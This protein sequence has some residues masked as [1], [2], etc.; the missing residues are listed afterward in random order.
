MTTKPPRWLVRNVQ[1]IAGPPVDVDGALAAAHD[2]DTEREGFIPARLSG[3]QV[4]STVTGALAAAHD[5]DTEREGFIPARLSDTALRAAFVSGDAVRRNLRGTGP[6]LTKYASNPIFSVGQ[7]SSPVGVSGGAIQ[8][9]WIVN[10]VAETGAVGPYG[11]TYRIYFSSD[12]EG[13]TASVGLLTAAS[14]TGPWTSRGAIYAD[15]VTDNQTETASVVWNPV[16][17]LWFMYYHQVS[18][19]GAGAAECTILATSADGV[20]NWT[21]VGI[22]MDYPTNGVAYLPANGGIGYA[23]P[24]RF[25][26]RWY[27]HSLLAGGNYGTCALWSSDDGRV[28]TMDVRPLGFG[29]DLVAAGNRVEWNSGT[30]VYYN[31]QLCWMGLI[32]N[33]TSGGATR[34]TSY[35]YAP[36][37]PDFRRLLAPPLPLFSSLQAWE[38]SPADN[39]SGGSLLVDSDGSLVLAYSGSTTSFGL[40]IGV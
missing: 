11:E 15:A 12:H 17:Q 36:I 35:V 21:R 32:T 7:Q 13:S 4:L 38:T 34:V 20:S 22:V 19:A 18:V 25:G 16:E 10:V 2:T 29:S 23:R 30:V 31:G 14:R 37:S 39:R 6:K 40:A 26:G 3:A 1:A 9:P 28:W 5:T 33:F 27:A 24:F 8:W